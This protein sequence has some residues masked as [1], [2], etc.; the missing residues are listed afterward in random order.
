[1]WYYIKHMEK[2]ILD[3]NLFFNMEAGLSLG[4]K[5]EEAVR[6]VT[7]FAQKLKKNGGGV[8]LMPPRVV[9]EFLS[10]FADKKQ[11][12]LQ[13]FLASLSIKSPDISKIN[14]SAQVFY[15]LV[16]DIRERSY[17]GL[18]IGEEEIEKA[19]K[20]SLGKQKDLEKKDF[21]IGL[22]EFIKKFRQRYRNATRTGFLDSLADL[23][24]I[25][26]A[27]EQDGIII[28]TD[29]GVIKWG[30][31][32][33]VKEMLPSAWVRQLDELFLRLNRQG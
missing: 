27:K 20:N 28:T 22:G 2:Y 32:F 23:D 5:T 17:R 25:V 16:Q 6:K 26:L 24:L 31:I 11:V 7:D 33:G 8:F 10:F 12:F 4:D 15:Q 3:T 21:Q 9:E 19:A 29:E 1:M 13:D 18:S 30:R 14:F